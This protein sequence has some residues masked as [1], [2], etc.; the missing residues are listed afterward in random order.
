MVDHNAIAE[1]L[2]ERLEGK[3]DRYA[4]YEA[5]GHG[6]FVERRGEFSHRPSVLGQYSARKVLEEHGAVM[7]K[8]MYFEDENLMRIWFSS[9][10]TETR[11]V[12]K[13]RMVEETYTEEEEVLTL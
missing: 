1:T 6:S 13:T 5:S 10:E 2:N 3:D 11:E 7:I 8:S 4:R 12:E 9:I